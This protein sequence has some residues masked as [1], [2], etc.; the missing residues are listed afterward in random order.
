MGEVALHLLHLKSRHWYMYIELVTGS[1]SVGS[2][3]ELKN[4]DFYQT[5]ASKNELFLIIGRTY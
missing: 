2:K 4:W 5:W 1:A 3:H